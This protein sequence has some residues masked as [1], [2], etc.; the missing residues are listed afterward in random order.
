MTSRTDL[1]S[2]V[3][4]MSAAQRASIE[5][6]VQRARQAKAEAP[7][8]A[9]SIPRRPAGSEV[10]LS[11]AQER[12]WFLYQ[13][14]PESAVYNLCQALRIK[15]AL[16]LPTLTKALNEIVHRHEIVRTNF[17]AANGRAVQIIA[18]SRTLEVAEVD[19][20]A[21]AD[22]EAALLR[23]LDEG[24]RVPFNL[25]S[26]L[27]LRASVARLAAGEHVLMLTMHHIIS[28]GWSIGVIFRE[29]FAVYAA[30]RAGQAPALPELPLQ[31]GDFAHWERA[32]LDAAALEKP[33]AYW[34][35]QLAGALP[36]MQL[37]LDHPSSPAGTFRGGVRAI[38][39]SRELSLALKALSQRE[40]ATL[41]MTLLAAFQTLLHRVCGQDDMVVGFVVAG[42]RKVALEKLIGFFVQTLVARGDLSGDPT[43]QAL[44]GR[45]RTTTLGALAHADLPFEHLVRELRPERAA[46]RNPLFQVMFI[47]QNAPMTP[48]DV[49][50]LKLESIELDTG[51]AKFDLTL[52][53]MET[54]QGLRTA[55]EYNAELFEGATIERLLGTFQTL[56]TGIVAD[57]ARS[58]SRIPLLTPA[59]R[60]EILFKWNE[61]ALDYPRESTLPE[62]FEA[63]VRLKPDA[64]AI[65]GEREC[66]TYAEL[67]AQAE[68]IAARLRAAG[69]GPESLVGVFLNRTPALVAAI[70][71]VL[72]AGGAYVP[73]D[74][75]YPTDRLAFIVSDARMAALVTERALVAQRPAGEVSVVVIDDGAASPAADAKVVSGRAAT[76]ESLAYVIYTS[77]STGKPKG[78]QLMH[79][80]V[81]AHIA[82][83]KQLYAP[84]ELGGVFFSTSAS[85]DVSVFE[86]FCPLCLGGKIIVGDN[87]L[88][89]G[90][91]PAR[92]EVT[93][94]STVPSAMTEVLRANLIPASVTTV[95]L[96]GE[97][98][99]QPLVDSLYR[100]PHIKRVYDLY[101][102]TETTVYSTGGL[103]VAGGRPT[104]GRPLPNERAYVLDRHLEPVP[105][106]VAGELHIGGEKLARGYLNRPELTAERFVAAPFLPGERI[107]KTGD[108]ARFRADGTLEYLGRLDQQVKIRGYRVELGEIESAML[109]LPAIAEA[110]AI[111]RPDPTGG[112]RVIGY[113]VSVPEHV[114]D[115]AAL[116]E[117]LTN[118]LPDFMVPS[119]IVVLEKLPVTAN[120]KLDRRAL[121]DPDFSARATVSATPRSLT[122][123]LLSEMW[124]DVLSL[125]QVGVDD[126]FFDVGGHSLLAAQVLAR[127][128]AGFGTEISM[129]QFF[130]APTVARLAVVVEDA[131]IAEIR[132]DEDPKTPH[133]AQAIVA[134][135]E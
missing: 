132:A 12:L 99:P 120:G 44:L 31:F 38:T 9:S 57:P 7:E 54:P 30:L 96:A 87:I 118:D 85:F 77:G 66:F 72:K 61:T 16:D 46:N 37:P 15:G 63:Q 115:P 58:I 76:A 4:E 133:A 21:A 70:L 104:L 130:S 135:K 82:W 56:L 122:E 33:L 18:P 105:V 60:N 17:S 80:G 89:I 94:L 41:F 23:W 103:R 28:D 88:Q 111:T 83:A 79:R 125:K 108:G 124:C 134:A 131:L 65:V 35:Q 98:L 1:P 126:N 25:T 69:V 91:H 129:R 26:D 95:A 20:A 14:E 19:F 24:A 74:P 45:V 123:E 10:P 75:A 97:L 50:E 47:L 81:A 127:V 6:R 114:A 86:M 68:R 93:L 100:L 8:A 117:Q 109:R 78:V 71:G 22:H 119:A 52:S 43:F 39:L 121:P 90:R 128:H 84:G 92:D 34:K 42:R 107:Y 64:I 36:V 112:N 106:G 11:F 113:V 29:L 3:L 51:T 59:E 5:Q 27:L 2:P 101:G 55:F 116:R 13:L 62:L 49:P 40:N 110:V 102:P 48:A 53:M 32:T 67:N 73:L